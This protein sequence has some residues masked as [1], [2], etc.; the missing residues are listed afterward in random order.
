MVISEGCLSRGCSPRGM[1]AQGGVYPEGVCPGS[2]TPS[3]SREK[4]PCQL[5]AGMHPPPV[6]RISDRCKNIAM[7]QTS[8]AGRNNC[9]DLSNW[10]RNINFDLANCSCR[11]DVYN[12]TFVIQSVECF[13]CGFSD[14]RIF[15]I[16]NS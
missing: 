2:C 12:Y 1:S 14:G 13:D 7:S 3:R 4:Q 15:E 10:E 8:F 9:Y 5:H 16:T 6:N 11:I